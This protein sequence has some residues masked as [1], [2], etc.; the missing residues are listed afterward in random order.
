MGNLNKP[1]SVDEVLVS[2]RLCS[3]G[4]GSTVT[5]GLTL[6]PLTNPSTG[7]TGIKKARSAVKPTTSANTGACRPFSIQY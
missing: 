3:M 6:A 1:L 4:K 5:T 2:G 7:V